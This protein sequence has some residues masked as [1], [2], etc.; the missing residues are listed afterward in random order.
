VHRILQERAGFDAE[1]IINIGEQFSYY[2]S[3]GGVNEFVVSHL[4][5]VRPRHA[6]FT[7]P[8]YTALHR[9]RDSP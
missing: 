4:V 8:N 3:P 1:D 2:T 7:F 9:R 5:E 6:P